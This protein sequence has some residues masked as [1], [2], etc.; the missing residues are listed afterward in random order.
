MV[1]TFLKLT[2]VD[3][4]SNEVNQWIISISE[5]SPNCCDE[6]LEITERDLYSVHVVLQD[7]NCFGVTL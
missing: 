6:L 3:E 2:V 7:F 5:V 4:S 1:N